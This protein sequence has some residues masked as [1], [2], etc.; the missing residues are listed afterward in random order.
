MEFDVFWFKL[1]LVARL[2]VFS[3]TWRKP[4]PP[5][6]RRT[7]PTNYQI[8]E[9]GVAEPVTYSNADGTGLIPVPG[10]LVDEERTERTF[11]NGGSERFEHVIDVELPR[12]IV[13]DPKIHA[14]L[15]IAGLTYA[16]V[17]CPNKNSF[18]T[19]VTA[20][21]VGQAQLKPGGR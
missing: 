21:R 20:K 10:A 5:V 4:Q 12:S 1:P 9:P 8:G 6:R 19:Q 11:T 7:L 2:T 15:L 3:T 18:Y 16:I 14:R 13:P 17:A